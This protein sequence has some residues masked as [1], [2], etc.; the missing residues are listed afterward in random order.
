MA[1]EYVTCEDCFYAYRTDVNFKECLHPN[2]DV[3]MTW[4]SRQGRC[5]TTD[6][7]IRPFPG[8]FPYRYIIMCDGIRCNG[9]L[10]L[11]AHRDM[12]GPKC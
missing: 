1:I 2:K 5:E 10:C 11:Y 4:N 12:N 9:S 7:S 6:R 8:H 3:H